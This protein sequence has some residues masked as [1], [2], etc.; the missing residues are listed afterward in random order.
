METTKRRHGTYLYAKKE[1][2]IEDAGSLDFLKLRIAA[3]LH[4][5]GKP[6]CWANEEPWS[7]HVRHTQEIVSETLGKDIAETAMRHHSGQS[8]DDSWKPVTEEEKIID[9]ADDIASGADRREEAYRKRP[10]PRPPISLSHP[11]SNGKPVLEFTARDLALA[12]EEIRKILSD[13]AE[14]YRSSPEKAYLSIFQGLMKSPFGIIPAFTEPPINDHSL[15]DHS[16]LTAA[17]SMCIA[18]ESGYIGDSA[19]RYRFA[20]VSGDADRIQGYIN[21]SSRLPDLKEG[22]RLVEE[23][24]NIASSAVSGVLGPECILFVGGG[25]FL[26]L[27][28]PGLAEELEM[29]AKEAFEEHTAGELTMTVNHIVVDGK[30]VKDSFG[31]VWCEAAYRLRLRK[32]DRAQ[33]A[34]VPV[35]VDGGACDVCLRRKATHADTKFLPI[36]ASPRPERLCDVCWQRRTRGSGIQIDCLRDEKEFVGLLKVDGDKMGEIFGGERLSEFKKA[37]SPSRLSAISKMVDDAFRNTL[38]NIV[39][40]HGGECVFA[41]GDDLLALS[42]GRE[43]LWL[44]GDL[45]EAFRKSMNGRATLSAGVVVFKYRLPLYSALE[46]CGELL[47]RSK[48]AGRGGITFTI[49][50]G[51]GA[52]PDEFRGRSYE[53]HPRPYRWEGF[54]VLLSLVSQLDREEVARTQIRQIVGAAVQKDVGAAKDLVKYGMG[55][56]VIEWE[57]GKRIMGYLDT[58]VLVDAYQVHTLFRM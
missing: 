47:R 52:T 38:T 4:D 21:I 1:S 23:A 51:V 53:K 30:T 37:V 44:A 50:G 7:S 2:R 57:L 12:S 26:A 34:P 16:K 25:N 14:S 46:C 56:G 45:A 48:D 10:R 3:L 18:R 5:V 29:K 54:D 39:K 9:L 13:N 15:F 40:R 31:S 36:D 32:L 17:L 8:Y 55:R 43:A 20:L 28:P 11:L 27:S 49:M 24:T 35:E 6:V 41:G 42:P 22:S 19:E 58:G 33:V